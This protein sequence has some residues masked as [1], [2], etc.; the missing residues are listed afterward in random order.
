MFNHWGTHGNPKTRCP[1]NE[2]AH[3]GGGYGNHIKISI[4]SQ[5]NYTK[6]FPDPDKL[7]C[8]TRYIRLVLRIVYS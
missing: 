7:I 3:T 2:T 1:E 5:D 8:N 4:Q 6:Y